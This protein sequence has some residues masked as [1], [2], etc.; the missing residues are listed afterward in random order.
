MT[1]RPFALP[2]DLPT[3]I[4]LIPPTFQYPENDAWSMQADE[5]EDFVESM[6]G[7]RRIWWL[8]RIAGWLSPPLRDILR[9]YVWEEDGQ[10]VALTNVLRQGATDYWYIAN[11]SVLPAYRRR[12]IARKLVE[13]S[14]DYAKGRG[15]KSI[16]LDVVAGNLP[17]Y[18]LYNE[19]L[20][21]EFIKS[22]SQLIYE[23]DAPPDA[24]P[25]PPGYSLA[26]TFP[27]NWR[28][29]YELALRITP[30][31]VR[32]Y[33]P[34]EKGRFKQPAFLRLLVPVI[35][36]AIGSATQAYL[37]HHADS[38]QIVAVASINVRTRSGGTNHLSVNLDP[39]HAELAPF[40]V[41]HLVREIAARSPGRRIE[42]SAADWQAPLLDTM[43]DAGFIKRSDYH[44]MGLL[45]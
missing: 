27:M 31:V 12:G 25:Q 17:A 9:G 13:A 44:T 35:Q 30:E 45:C 4:D 32:K 14:M 43:L 39:A 2:Q 1:L 33:T 20:G 40:L 36:K 10:P 29:R 19:K 16:T 42:S 7:F 3:L 23:H 8:L 6:D 38:G 5:V 28:P 24:V 22:E 18:K 21:F 34:V 15:A 26:P 11:V 37:A 41:R